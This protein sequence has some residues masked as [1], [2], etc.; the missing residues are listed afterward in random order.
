MQSAALMLVAAPRNRGP[1]WAEFTR[2]QNRLAISNLARSF[3]LPRPQAKIAILAM[4]GALT[5]SFDEQTLS[6]GTLARLI[7]LLGKNDYERVLETPT[8][9][10]ATSTQV[11][12]NDALTALAGRAASTRIANSA[13]AA[14][15]IS[16]MIAEYLLPV[17]AA[18]FMGALAAKTRAN[19]LALARND[20]AAQAAAR[21]DETTAPSM[22]LPS[23]RGSS[24]FFAGSTGIGPGIGADP[25]REKLYREL[26]ER[27]RDGA[28]APGMPDPLN[29]VREIMAEGIGVRA[30]HAPW[31]AHLQRWGMDALQSASMQMQQR[32]RDLRSRWH[33]QS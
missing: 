1:I 13:A 11:I 9:M 19:L 21:P 18:L 3:H 22:Q 25:A 29:A 24:G 5:Q 16:E 27:I 30:R 20:D 23:G 28:K 7:E 6:R 2:A 26:A 15:G 14:A 32:L 33:D 31:F 17:V 8:L 4:L 10:G 12:G